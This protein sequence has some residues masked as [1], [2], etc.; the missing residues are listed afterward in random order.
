MLGLVTRGVTRLQVIVLYNHIQH[1]EGSIGKN[2]ASL[3]PHLSLASTSGA[4]HTPLH[5]PVIL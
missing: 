4:L 5:T 1:V 3:S 2:T